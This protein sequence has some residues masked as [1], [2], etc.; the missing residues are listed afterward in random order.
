VIVVR[1]MGGLGNQLFQFAFGQARLQQ[2][3]NVCFDAVNGFAR[4]PYCRAYA[5]DQFRIEVCRA[6]REDVPWGVNW[7]SPFHKIAKCAWRLYPKSHRQVYYESN[8]FM[9]EPQASDPLNPSR[10]FWGYWQNPT[11]CDSI[12]ERLRDM[13]R[14]NLE[15]ARFSQLRAEIAARRSISVHIRRYR[16]LNHQGQLILAAGLNQGVCDASYY[17]RGVQAIPGHMSKH[18][19]IFSDDPEWA[20]QN[21]RLPIQCRYVADCGPFTAAEELMLMAAC[22]NYVIS[23]SSFSWWGAYLGKNPDKTVVAPKVWNKSI[24]GDQSGVCPADWIR[25]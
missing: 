1:L 22:Q 17:H 25:I 16:D 13:L 7:P 2:G 6:S 10:Y 24:K 20:K 8:P 19:Y 23:N 11:Y 14:L 3:S 18:A 5:L 15:A 12:K 4:D 9:Y 21:L